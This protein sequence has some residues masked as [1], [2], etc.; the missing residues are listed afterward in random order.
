MTSLDGYARPSVA[1]DPVVL[2]VY[3]GELSVVVDTENSTLPRLPGTFVREGETLAQAL[4]RGL[5][6]KLNIQ[7]ERIEQLHVFDQPGRDPRGW[8]ISV[9]HYALVHESTLDELRP[10]DVRPVDDLPELD[11]DHRDMIEMAVQRI[12]SEYLAEPDPWRVLEHFTLSELRS[13]HER[14]DR[15]TLLRDTF[16]RI[17]EP[18]LIEMTDV[19]PLSTG[20]RPSRVW[21]TPTSDEK[22]KLRYGNMT[23]RPVRRASRP[24][25]DQLMSPQDFMMDDAIVFDAPMERS[26]SFRPPAP[27]FTVEFT[28]SDGESKVHDN[29]REREAFRL[30]DNFVFDAKTALTDDVSVRPVSAVMRDDSGDVV[31][32]RAF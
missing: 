6:T 17:M 5:A 28:W 21:R 12:R 2:A 20:G 18:Q 14:I 22:H 31:R 4:A 26:A 24:R 30:F 27:R 7:V 32:D 13:F 11:F 29:L 15:G 16:R 10:R 19:A 23:E 8:V 9:A 3:R 25:S 1:V